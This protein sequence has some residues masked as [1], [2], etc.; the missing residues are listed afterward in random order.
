VTT[1]A[2]APRATHREIRFDFD[3]VRDRSKPSPLDLS[4]DVERPLLDAETGDVAVN[5]QAALIGTDVRVDNMAWNVRE[6]RVLPTS[7]YE[8]MVWT[9]ERELQF[10]REEA[11][12]LNLMRTVMMIVKSPD[13]ATQ[14]KA[15]GLDVVAA[16]EAAAAAAAHNDGWAVLGEVARGSPFHGIVGPAYGPGAAAK[17]LQ[18]HAGAGAVSVRVDQTYYGGK[19]QHVRDVKDAFRQREQ[20]SAAVAMPVVADDLVLYPYQVR[21]VVPGGGQREE[22]PHPPL[23]GNHIYNHNHHHD[24]P[25]LSSTWPSSSAPTASRWG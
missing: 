25:A 4:F 9:K 13:P 19:Y 1:H 11:P 14:A 20:D 5:R 15:A 8:S 2:H 22:T 18:K 7:L 12:L 6:E 16:L 10:V 3:S 24:P 23:N 21:V 17:A